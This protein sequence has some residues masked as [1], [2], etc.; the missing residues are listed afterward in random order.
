MPAFPEPFSDSC[1]T[2]LSFVPQYPSGL[3]PWLRCDQE[4]HG[5]SNYCACDNSG[6]QTTI[7]N[8][9]SFLYVIEIMKKVISALICLYRLA[10]PVLSEEAEM[11]GQLGHPR[12]IAAASRFAKA[13]ACRYRPGEGMQARG[14]GT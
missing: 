13:R 11:Q 12:P 3:P 6:D 14:T 1:Y 2:I 9:S 8:Y 7:H 5:P 4:S 10:V